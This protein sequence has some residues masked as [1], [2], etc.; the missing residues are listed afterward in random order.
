RYGEAVNQ[1][2]VYG[3]TG[4]DGN[5]SYG[6]SASLGWQRHSS[7]TDVAVFYSGTYGGVARYSTAN[8]Y[9]QSLSVSTNRMLSARWMLT[10]SG[11]GGDTT[12]AQFLYQPSYASQLVQA[13]PT[14]DDLA[15]AFSVGRFSSNQVASVLTSAPSLE[16]PARTLLLG[17]RILS[18]SGQIS[19]A[20]ARSS[21]LSFHLSS[22][23]AAGVH[24]SD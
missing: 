24:R 19:L 7:R 2:R 13:A 4:L 12:T 8:G 9:S 20:Y 6:G 5:V 3:A 10:L 17:D 14:F 23:T 21:R 11:G 1:L 22:F 16:S 15:A 18:Y